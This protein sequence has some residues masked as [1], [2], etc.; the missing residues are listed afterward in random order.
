MSPLVQVL[1]VT[2]AL[3]LQVLSTALNTVC[4]TDRSNLSGL[5]VPQINGLIT[6]YQLHIPKLTRCLSR[7][8]W[9][10][11]LTTIS[12]R[13]HRTPVEFVEKSV[14]YSGRKQQPWRKPV[15]PFPSCILISRLVWS[16]LALPIYFSSIT[17]RCGLGQDGP[18]FLH[19]SPSFRAIH[20]SLISTPRDLSRTNSEVKPLIRCPVPGHRRR[21][22]LILSQPASPNTLILRRLTVQTHARPPLAQNSHRRPAPPDHHRQYRFI[23]LR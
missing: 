23:Y 11:Q 5:S 9:L 19:Y 4:N 12:S 14:S 17:F 15:L 2:L 7:L 8:L 18:G 13:V 20:I 10:H 1:C 22:P 21:Q 6:R 3:E 16:D